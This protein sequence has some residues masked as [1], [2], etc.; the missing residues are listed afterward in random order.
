M[1]PRLAGEWDKNRAVQLDTT[2]ERHPIWFT[3][4]HIQMPRG[5]PVEYRYF[6]ASGG[7]F[8]VRHLDRTRS[9]TMGVSHTTIPPAF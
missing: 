1:G 2:P 3:K 7:E 8:Q 9:P 6:I 5:K 4:E